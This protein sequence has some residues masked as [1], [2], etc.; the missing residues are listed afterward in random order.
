MM[1]GRGFTG[2]L[3]VAIV[4]MPAQAFAQTAFTPPFT[5]EKRAPAQHADRYGDLPLGAVIRTDER[6]GRD[7]LF[8]GPR[9]SDY[10]NLLEKPKAYQDPNLWP[11]KRPTYFIAQLKMPPGTDLTIRGRFPHARYFKFALYV[12]ERNTF[13][14]L[15]NGSLSSYEIQPDPCSRN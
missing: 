2:A 6:Y 4:P 15:S 3:S 12:F 8:Q 1:K 13:V 5:L 9:G 10:W 11:D 14:T 7:A